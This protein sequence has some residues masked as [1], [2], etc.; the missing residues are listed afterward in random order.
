MAAKRGRKSAASLAVVTPIPGQRHAPP[1]ELTDEQADIWRAVVATKPAT[2][3]TEDTHPLLMGYCRH[4]V[5]GRS[6]A[7]MIDA[8]DMALAET[9]DGLKR[10]EKLLQMR[11]RESRAMTALA[12][13]MRLTQQAQLKA[14]TAATRAAS[15][16]GA[17][18][19]WEIA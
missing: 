5:A 6:L 4:V 10:Y 12:R 17:R 15:V 18:K 11:E 2:W 16:G 1:D 8:F 14:E 7:R 13:S 19:P 3:F 9:E